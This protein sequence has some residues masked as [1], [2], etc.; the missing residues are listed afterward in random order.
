VHKAIYQKHLALD[1]LPASEGGICGKFNLSNCCLHIDDEGKGIEEIT[2]GMRK[3]AHVPVQTWRGRNPTDLFGGWFSALGGFK[4]LKGTEI[5]VS[6]ACLIV[7]CL[8]PLVLWSIRTIM[9]ATVQGKMAAHVMML[10][11][12][13]PLKSG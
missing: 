3:I 7:P 1:Y 13:K 2:D 12:Y 4:I 8:V 6:G 11:R 9:E 5:L 10:W